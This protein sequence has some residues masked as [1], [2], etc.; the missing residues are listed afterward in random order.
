[1]SLQGKLRDGCKVVVFGACFS[2]EQSITTLHLGF[3]SVR[4]A[5]GDAKLGYVHPRYLQTG[6]SLRSLSI[7]ML[8]HSLC[9]Q[10]N[11]FLSNQCCVQ[12]LPLL[13]IYIVDGGP[14]HA[15][16]VRVLYVGPSLCS[17]YIPV[18][19]EMDSL[20]KQG[21]V[22]WLSESEICQYRQ[23]SQRIIEKEVQVIDASY[24][25]NR[26]SDLPR[27]R[28]YE[29]WMLRA[30]QVDA[31]VFLIFYIYLPLYYSIEIQCLENGQE[32]SVDERQMEEVQ[33]AIMQLQH[34]HR[35]SYQ[36]QVDALHRN[37]QV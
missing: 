29:R 23:I 30:I 6:L 2:S 26:L 35:I 17:A 12:P 36:K 33:K 32:P 9:V 18:V 28:R 19:E 24:D 3:N 4:K 31:F 7:S 25:G 8:S 5:R 22:F 21:K 11:A 13:P 10:K 37:F 27:A 16:T 15:I 14:I 34:D 1:M 20:S